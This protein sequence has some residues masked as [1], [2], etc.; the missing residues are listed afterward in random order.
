MLKV[1]AIGNQEIEAG[2]VK[3]AAEVIARLRAKRGS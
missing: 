3:P 1:L 2:K